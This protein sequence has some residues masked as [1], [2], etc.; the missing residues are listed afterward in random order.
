MWIIK[1]L[2]TRRT[3]DK[4]RR[5]PNF[6]FTIGMS[7]LT[8]LFSRFINENSFRRRTFKKK[9]S[10]YHINPRVMNFTILVEH[11]F[12]SWY[13]QKLFTRCTWRKDDLKWYICHLL[14]LRYHLLS[15]SVL[16]LFVQIMV[17]I[18]YAQKK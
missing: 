11:S 7:I 6:C 16:F 9:K 15:N 17:V 12:V 18:L 14:A 8:I 10:P 1:S 4:G 13:R 2:L 5:F 3:F